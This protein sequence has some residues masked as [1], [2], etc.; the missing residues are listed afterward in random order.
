[1][2]TIRT[3]KKRQIILDVLRAGNSVGA[4]CDKAGIA[5]S[6][7]YDW[8]RDDSDFMAATEAAI[9]AGT[10]ILEDVAITRAVRQS[11]TLLI[12]LLKSRRPEKYRETTRHEHSAPGGGPIQHEHRDLSMFDADEINALR[13]LKRKQLAMT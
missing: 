9:E 4:A 12:F 13:T 2:R 6:A 10:D 11:D 3:P 1:M 8:R 5:R 7:Y